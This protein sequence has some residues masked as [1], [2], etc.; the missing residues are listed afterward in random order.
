MMLET[1]N[2]QAYAT[3]IQLLLLWNIL[4]ITCFWFQITPGCAHIHSYSYE[5][6]QNTEA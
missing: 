1:V 6:A 4:V 5:A 3:K 2:L